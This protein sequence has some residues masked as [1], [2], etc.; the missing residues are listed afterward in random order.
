M[1]YN[2][3]KVA[4]RGPPVLQIPEQIAREKIVG[5]LGEAGWVRRLAK[6]VVRGRVDLNTLCPSFRSG[7]IRFC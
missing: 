5:L 7:P 4:G 6:G 1:G 3:A 2:P